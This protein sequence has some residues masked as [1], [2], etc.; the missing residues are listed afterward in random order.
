[1]AKQT[2]K[3]KHPKRRYEVGVEI[4]PEEAKA[5]LADMDPDNRGIRWTHVQRIADKMKARLWKPNAEVV[6][7]DWNGVVVD[8]QHRLLG[9]I[10]SGVTVEMDVCYGVEPDSVYTMDEGR[11]RHLRDKISREFPDLKRKKIY[12]EIATIYTKVL[13]YDVTSEDGYQAWGRRNR[14]S[15]NYPEVFKWVRKNKA[16]LEFIVGE[17]KREGGREFMRPLSIMGALYFICH[18]VNPEEAVAFFTMMI[19][20]L[21]YKKGKED[22]AYWCRREIERLHA[23]RGKGGDPARWPYMTA[24]CRAF[25]AHLRGEPLHGLRDLRVNPGE[26][27]EKIDE[28]AIPKRGGRR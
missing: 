14:G 19:D 26:S 12:R 11:N 1:M 25:N 23:E 28:A 15:W 16:A 2:K 24:V 20:G 4:G 22:P 5:F 27:F 10:R 17:C 7:V 21:G 6:K 13:D 18:R 3:K 9:V 8:G